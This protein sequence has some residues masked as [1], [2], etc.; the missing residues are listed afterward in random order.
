[1]FDKIKIIRVHSD[2]QDLKKCSVISNIGLNV[3]WYKINPA[4]SNTSLSLF[5]NGSRFLYLHFR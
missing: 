2:L 5:G 1:M 4:Y 3:I